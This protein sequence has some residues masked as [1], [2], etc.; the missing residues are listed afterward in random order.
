MHLT[1]TDALALPQIKQCQVVAGILGLNREIQSINSFDA[2][3]VL[4]WLKPNELIL[5]TGYLF[6]DNP[7]QL[8]QFVI[9]LAK[10]NCSG[11]FIKLEE[12]PQTAIN[13]ANMANLPI[14]KIPPEFSLSEIMSPLL[15]EIVTR[16]NEHKELS[17]SIEDMDGVGTENSS[18]GILGMTEDNSSFHQITGGFICTVLPLTLQWNHRN[19]TIA[20]KQLIKTIETL[21]GQYKI[22]KLIRNMKLS[23]VIIYLDTLPLGSTSFYSQVIH[24]SQQIISTLSKHLP[25]ELTL[26]IGNYHKGINNLAN[27]L[28]EALQSIELGK[29]LNSGKEIYCYKDLATFKIL[30]YAPKNVLIDIV[31]DNLAPLKDHDD[32]T[33]SDLIKTLETYMQ[34]NLRPAETARKMG[35]HRNTIHFRIKSIKKRLGSDL[36]NDD[37]F[38]LKLALYA[39]RLLDNQ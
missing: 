3:D 39:K 38:T 4:S 15:R 29:R 9:E 34:C 5:T 12:I 16:Q 19:D 30:Q 2:P 8:D 7:Q 10:M 22:D 6:Q 37:L 27:S 23:L 36:S 35:V 26:G 21:T 20:Y 13:I 18:Y 24:L 33:E 25:L 17:Y 11:L 32:E 31:T 1:L 28:Q 14:L